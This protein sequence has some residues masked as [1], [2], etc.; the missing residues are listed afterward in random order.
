MIALVLAATL[1]A[2]FDV[3]VGKI[4]PELHSSS[5]GPTICSTTRMTLRNIPCRSR[6]ELWRSGRTT[7]T[8]RRF[9]WSS[10]SKS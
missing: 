7:G 10:R 6:T 9:W 8:P 2:N 5:F 3:E 1:S 4:R